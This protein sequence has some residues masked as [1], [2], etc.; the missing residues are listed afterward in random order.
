[1][2][3]GSDGSTRSLPSLVK[4]FPSMV[5]GVGGIV[6]FLPSF[7]WH[8]PLKLEVCEPLVLPLTCGSP[9]LTVYVPSVLTPTETFASRVSFPSFLVIDFDSDSPRMSCH[10]LP[11][12]HELLSTAVIF[13][14][15]ENECV[16][17]ARPMLEPFFSGASITAIEAL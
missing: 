5:V 16:I 7:G 1:M 9:T 11:R 17:V 3:F 14:V 8:C 6:R 15:E 4:E 13:S 12:S 10:V 2:R